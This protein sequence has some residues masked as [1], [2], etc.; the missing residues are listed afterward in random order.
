VAAWV[1]LTPTARPTDAAAEA[2]LSAALIAF[3]REGLAAYKRPRNIY[4]VM[5]LPRN[6][7]GKVVKHQLE[8]SATP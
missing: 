5:S 1:V 7:L 6:A 4:Y 8:A 3:C 2:A